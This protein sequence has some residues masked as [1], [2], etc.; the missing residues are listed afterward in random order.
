MRKKKKNYK[1]RDLA[2]Q[3]IERLFDLAENEHLHRPDRSDRY[4]A[5]ARQIG[6]RLRVRIP[7]HLKRKM[8][9][10]CYCYLS[11]DRTRIRLRDGILT[12][13][14]LQ[15]GKQ[16]RYP[17]KMKEGHHSICRRSEKSAHK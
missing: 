17:Y 11:P 7:T 12:V 14:C 1:T 9:R 6:M 5:L 15:C 10:Y 16:M 13:T 4:T 8:C 2:R 3:R